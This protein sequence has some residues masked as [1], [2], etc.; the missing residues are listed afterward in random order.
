VLLLPW[1]LPSLRIIFSQPCPAWKTKATQSSDCSLSLGPATEKL[2]G[3]PGYS[4]RVGQIFVW[5]QPGLF[6]L[7]AEQFARL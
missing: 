6:E 3:F 2:L 4:K 7:L 5:M 1:L